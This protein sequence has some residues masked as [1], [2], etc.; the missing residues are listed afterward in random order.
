MTLARAIDEYTALME[1]RVERLTAGERERQ[2]RYRQRVLV[3]LAAALLAIG[4]AIC[5]LWVLFL[6]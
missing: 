4:F 3:A 1:R 2:R 5:L 6:L